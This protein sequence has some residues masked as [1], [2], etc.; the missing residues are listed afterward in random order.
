VVGYWMVACKLNG[1]QQLEVTV[2]AEIST[3]RLSDRTGDSGGFIEKNDDIN[4]RTYGL[5]TWR[6]KPN[7]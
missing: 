5:K 1:Q 2:G 6:L 3:L 4:T 7:C